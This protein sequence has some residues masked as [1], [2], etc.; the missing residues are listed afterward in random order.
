MRK[1]DFCDFFQ[2]F[3]V[4]QFREQHFAVLLVNGADV[5][6]DL[7]GFP[8]QAGREIVVVHFGHVFLEESRLGG[9]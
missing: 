3:T 8:F 2:A 5:S 9:K 6:E 4:F 7:L 1:E